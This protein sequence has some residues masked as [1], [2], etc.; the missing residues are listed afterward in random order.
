MGKRVQ[1]FG[2][3]SPRQSILHELGDPSLQVGRNYQKPTTPQKNTD[4]KKFLTQNLDLKYSKS[5]IT[6]FK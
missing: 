3:T 2:Y 5:K 1:D 4:K 6:L